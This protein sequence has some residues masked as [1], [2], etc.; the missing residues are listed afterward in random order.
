MESSEENIPS[1]SE[2]ENEEEIEEVSMTNI[3]IP[4]PEVIRTSDDSSSSIGSLGRHIG[5]LRRS[6][7]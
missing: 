7:I 5:T 6:N 4:R 1:S 2:S 3:Q